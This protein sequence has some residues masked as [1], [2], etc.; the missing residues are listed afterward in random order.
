MSCRSVS[1]VNARECQLGPAGMQ[2]RALLTGDAGR[3]TG[4]LDWFGLP[5]GMGDGG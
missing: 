1:M 4:R 3:M 5:G 2:D